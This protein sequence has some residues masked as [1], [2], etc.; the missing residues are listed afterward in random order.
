MTEIAK[1]VLCAI[2]FFPAVIASCFVQ[3]LVWIVTGRLGDPWVIR[4]I[5]W[6]NDE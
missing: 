4:L 2:L 1:R 6:A 5:E 3:P